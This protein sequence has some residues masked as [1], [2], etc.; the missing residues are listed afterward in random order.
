MWYRRQHRG[1]ALPTVLYSRWY[2]VGNTDV[3][4]EF[5]VVECRVMIECR[6]V[7]IVLMGKWAV[8]IDIGSQL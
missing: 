2:T 8:V 4:H 1:S 6:A 5:M 3:L 7:R